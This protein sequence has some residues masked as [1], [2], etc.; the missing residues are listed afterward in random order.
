MEPDQTSPMEQS[1]LGPYCLNIGY[2]S[3]ADET[4]DDNCLEFKLFMITR[5][6]V[7]LSDHPFNSTEQHI[8]ESIV[9]VF[10]V[11]C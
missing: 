6:H 9:F 10:F 11:I 3:T 5:L 8:S 1:D 2:Q 4:A 7:R